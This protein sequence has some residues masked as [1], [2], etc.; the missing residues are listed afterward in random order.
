MRVR[1]EHSVVAQEAAAL[2]A[3]RAKESRA[4]V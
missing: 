3:A 4:C 1:L 2:D